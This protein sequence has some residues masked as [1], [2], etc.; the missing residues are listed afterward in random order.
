MSRVSRGRF[1]AA[2]ADG[3]LPSYAGELL[4]FF[5]IFA[6]LQISPPFFLYLQIGP[7]Y[8]LLFSLVRQPGKA[9]ILLGEDR[10]FKDGFCLVKTTSH[11]EGGVLTLH[12]AL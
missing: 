8:P 3:V 11:N 12:R 5:G 2:S 10:R 7:F 1:P 9:L 4:F 6:N